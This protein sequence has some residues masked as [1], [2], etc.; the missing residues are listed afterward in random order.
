MIFGITPLDV[1]KSWMKIWVRLI[2]HCQFLKQNFFSNCEYE[3]TDQTTSFKINSLRCLEF[4]RFMVQ[5][6]RSK[7]FSNAICLNANVW[8]SIKILL[9]FVLKGSINKIPTLVHT[10]AWRR[11]GDKPLSEPMMLSLL[12]HIC[13]TQ[14]QWVKT[15]VVFLDGHPNLW[16]ILFGYVSLVTATGNT[17]RVLSCGLIKL[18]Q[19]IRMN[20]HR[21]GGGGGYQWFSDNRLM[22]MIWITYSPFNEQCTY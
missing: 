18:L 2:L 14:H 4:S 15:A 6:I 21:R 3:F 10:M 19:F 12:T 13:V 7:I 22:W 9:N 8:I 1:T 17:K 5:H 20:S 11:P 16:F